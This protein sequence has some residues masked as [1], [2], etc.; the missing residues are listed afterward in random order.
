MK[1]IFCKWTVIIFK[2]L[3]K[4]VLSRNLEKIHFLFQIIYIV[5]HS[6]L[7]LLY[8]TSE[9]IQINPDPVRVFLKITI[10][11]CV[12]S[13]YCYLS[14]SF[15]SSSSTSLSLHL[16]SLFA[17]ILSSIRNSTN[18]QPRYKYSFLHW[19][20][21]SMALSRVMGVLNVSK[22]EVKQKNKFTTYNV[23]P[24]CH[25]YPKSLIRYSLKKTGIIWSF[26]HSY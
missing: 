21:I 13:F 24:V 5:L 4:N 16:P 17:Y 25:L 15:P 26:N 23:T 6:K 8:N 19:I 9:Q 10:S 7:Q 1:C 2:F 18:R 22:L 11:L 20:Q 3:S 14:L 12:W